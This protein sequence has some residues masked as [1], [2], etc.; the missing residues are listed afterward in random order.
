MI[1][2][3][4]RSEDRTQMF[5]K[6]GISE[7]NERTIRKELITPFITLL[8]NSTTTSSSKRPPP[9]TTILPLTTHP[10]SFLLFLQPPKKAN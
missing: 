2:G 6:P 10:V 5:Y 1:R 8:N 9:T 7:N 4:V 3:R